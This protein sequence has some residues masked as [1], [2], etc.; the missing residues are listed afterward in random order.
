LSRNGIFK[1]VS[2][3][4]EARALPDATMRF[5]SSLFCF[6]KAGSAEEPLASSLS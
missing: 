2:L 4:V 1:A 6:T 5:T 3:R